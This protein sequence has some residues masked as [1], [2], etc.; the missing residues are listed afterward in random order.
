MQ[1]VKFQILSDRWLKSSPHKTNLSTLLCAA[2]PHVLF[3][4][5]STVCLD[6]IESRFSLVF[7]STPP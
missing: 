5:N 2:E 6:L 1:A 4:V 7:E 3:P